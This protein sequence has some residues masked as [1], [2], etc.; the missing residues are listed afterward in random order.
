MVDDKARRAI[1]YGTRQWTPEDDLASARMGLQRRLDSQRARRHAHQGAG[2][3]TPAARPVPDNRQPIAQ[4]TLSYAE[5]LRALSLA[6]ADQRGVTLTRTAHNVYLKLA[7]PSDEG[8]AADGIAALIEL[9]LAVRD[10]LEAS[11]A[12]RYLGLN[13]L[14]HELGSEAESEPADHSTERMG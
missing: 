6:A 3:R 5:L 10:R 2:E 1:D 4:V 11:V 13:G 9:E 14:D 7:N 8:S 12:R